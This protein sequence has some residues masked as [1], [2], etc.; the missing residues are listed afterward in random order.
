MHHSRFRTITSSYYRG[1][2]GIIVV[3]DISDSVSFSNV[4]KW[5]QEI[6]NHACEGTKKLLVGNKCDLDAEGKRQVSHN[7]AKDFADN[8]GLTLIEASAKESI[9]VDKCFFQIT[10]DI[11]K[12]FE[13]IVW[14][15]AF[16]CLTL[17][18]AQ[19]LR[20]HATHRRRSLQPFGRRP[21]GHSEC[22][23]AKV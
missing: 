4:K 3:Y 22:T 13:R 6:A 15:F 9:N 17:G 18:F 10:E 21:Q 14:L 8:L 1:A 2:H 7:M 19:F 5:L 23:E 11:Q 12:T 16:V 20:G